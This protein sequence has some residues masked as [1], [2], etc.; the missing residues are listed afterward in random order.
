MRPFD[1][2][3]KIFRGLAGNAMG[4]ILPN[5]HVDRWGRL[6]GNIIGIKDIIFGRWAPERIA[7]L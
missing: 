4:S 1:V 5:S 6:K 7:E 3:R 2:Y